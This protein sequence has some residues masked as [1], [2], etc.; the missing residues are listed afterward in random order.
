MKPGAGRRRAE[1]GFLL[2]LGVVFLFNLDFKKLSNEG[3]DSRESPIQDPQN[4]PIL[5]IISTKICFA[6][7]GT[8]HVEA[9]HKCFC[10]TAR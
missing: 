7:T 1:R 2:Y 3:E 10:F 4:S 8:Q 5:P 6:K 9:D